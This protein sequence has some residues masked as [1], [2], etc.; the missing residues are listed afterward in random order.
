MIRFNASL[1]KVTMDNEG[2]YK[3]VLDVPSSDIDAMRQLQ[4]TVQKSLIIQAEVQDEENITQDENTQGF[5]EGMA[6]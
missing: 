4:L 1:W 3:V 6:E 5:A 2:A